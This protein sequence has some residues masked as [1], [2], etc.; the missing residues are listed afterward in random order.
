MRIS[1]I[2]PVYNRDWFLKSCIDSLLV[3]NVK[4]YEIIVV[5]DASNDETKDI[6]DS[7]Q[8]PRLRIFHNDTQR[9][10]SFSRNRAA[11]EAQGDILALIDSDCI[12]HED[13]LERLFEP[14][15]KDF[16]VMIAGGKI[17]D[18]DSNNFWEKVNSRGDFVS[19]NEGYVKKVFGCNMAI[20]RD[21]FAKNKFDENV[22][23]AEELDL[24]L[25]CKKQNKE[26]YYTPEA[27]VVHFRRNSFLGTI[28]QQFKYGFWNTYVN[29]KNKEFPFISW[30]AG[31]L[32]LGLMSV[33]LGRVRIAFGCLLIYLGLVSYIGVSQKM[34]EIKMLIKI[35]PGFLISC[36]SNSIGSLCGLPLGITNL[37]KKNESI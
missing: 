15:E 1:V 12:P 14:F 2:V 29:L 18:H 7:Y 35:Y 3:Q 31:V 9:G 13:W 19:R 16:E 32:S 4:D 23:P 34:L 26:I 27:Q 24:C 22:Y 21:F 20:R 5:N 36:L 10:P 17:L 28:K 37:F 33:A 30:G 11:F 6:L 25:R 8:D